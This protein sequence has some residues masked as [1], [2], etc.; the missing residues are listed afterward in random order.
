LVI[1]ASAFFLFQN[2]K[3]YS[4]FQKDIQFFEAQQECDLHVS[5]C[6][7]ILQN[8]KKITLDIDKPF[9]SSEEMRFNVK[10]EGFEDEKL[11][12]QIYGLN[13]NMGIFEQILLK[14]DGI[15]RGNVLLPTCM[16][17]KMVWKVNIISQKEGI[18]ASFVLELL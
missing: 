7:V 17:G 9:K 12:A 14:T 11:L 18:G 5:S 15:Y 1:A 16:S 13:M 4:F 2:G 3:I 8:D 10:A 6:E